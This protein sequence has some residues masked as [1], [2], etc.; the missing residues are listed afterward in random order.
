MS[1]GIFWTL[2]ILYLVW[3]VPILCPGVVYGIAG[4]FQI[5]RQEQKIKLDKET[6]QNLKTIDDVIGRR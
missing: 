1:E 6:A 4:G 2:G 3:W 5:R